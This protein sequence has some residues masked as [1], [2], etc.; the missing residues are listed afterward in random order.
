MVPLLLWWAKVDQRRAQATSLLAVA[1]A[2]IVGTAS[3]AAG[4]IFPLIP[5][6]ILAAGAVAG[7]PVGAL[8]LR[9]LSITWLRWSFVAFVMAMA[10]TV[11][12]TAPH[13]EIHIELNIA[14]T[15]ILFAVGLVMGLTAGLFGIGGGIIAI[16]LIMVIFSVGD[17]EAKGISLIAMAPA[18]LSGSYSHLRFGTAR[19]RDGIWVAIGV[20]IATPLGSLGAFSLPE[21]YANVIFGAFAATIAISLAVRAL[22]GRGEL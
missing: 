4:G 3:Y 7:A 17:L 5:A 9:S 18:A 13:R 6:L 2:A 22:R 21:T 16:P 1:P 14:A 19:L 15:I 12:F 8:V 10:I 11:M 20:L